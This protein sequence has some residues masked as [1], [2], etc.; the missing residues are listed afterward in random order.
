MT[1]AYW[2]V[3]AAGILP[4]VWVFVAKAAPGFDNRTPRLYLEGVTGWRRL[5]VWAQYNAFEVLPLFIAAVIIAHQLGAPQASLNALALAF[6]GFRVAH[7][8]FYLADR[9]TLRSL[10]W[11]GGFAC[12]VALFVI[13]A[14]G[15]ANGV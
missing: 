15:A 7:G 2:C 9:P 10:V 4:Y 5:A 3:L 13:A 8:V 1:T 11:T 6:L 14:G 12:I